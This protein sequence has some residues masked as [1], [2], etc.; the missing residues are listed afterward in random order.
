[1]NEHNVLMSAM[2]K[3]AYDDSLEPYGYYFSLE[4]HEFIK[5]NSPLSSLFH[6]AFSIASHCD[7][8]SPERPNL[9]AEYVLG[10]YRVDFLLQY[11]SPVVQTLKDGVKICSYTLHDACFIELDGFNYHDRDRS[12]FNYER[13]RQ[14]A[15][16]ETGVP[17]L[18]FTHDDIEKDLYSCVRRAIRVGLG[19]YYKKMAIG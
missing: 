19:F 17:L 16:I 1:M 15:I 14:N 5:F 18:R 7:G 9:I 12:Q 13:E 6:R 4:T 10:K 8:V 3:I 2:N 11:K